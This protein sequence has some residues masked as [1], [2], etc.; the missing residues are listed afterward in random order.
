M[1][2]RCTFGVLVN[3]YEEQMQSQNYWN[4]RQNQFGLYLHVSS[5]LFHTCILYCLIQVLLVTVLYATSQQ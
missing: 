2:F 5:V 4:H 1:M 3:S